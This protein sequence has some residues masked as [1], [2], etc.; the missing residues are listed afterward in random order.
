VQATNAIEA[1]SHVMVL[2]DADGVADGL[3]AALAQ[4]IL[5]DFCRT[6]VS[7]WLPS[8]L[9]SF[10]TPKTSL[11]LLKL[12]RGALTILPQFPFSFFLLFL[13]YSFS[14]LVTQSCAFSF[15]HVTRAVLEGATIL[16]LSF[17]TQLQMKQGLGNPNYFD[18]RG[19]PHGRTWVAH[20]IRRRVLW[21]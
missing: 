13:P 10:F 8:N 9:T 1:G 3:V 21:S 16:I 14:P 2:G 6:K 11:P 4:V 12:A 5:D 18:S 17:P 7:G 19:S 15:E 20:I